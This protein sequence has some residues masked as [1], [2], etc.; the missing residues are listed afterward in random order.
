MVSTK[1]LVSTLLLA[2][3]GTFAPNNVAQAAVYS[4]GMNPGMALR[5]EENTILAWKKAMVEFLPRYINHDVKMP[6]EYSYTFGLL[7]DWL[8]WKVDWKDITYEYGEFDIR[9]CQFGFTNRF[10]TPMLQISFP[11]LK[12]W[13][14]HAMQK[15]N[16]WILPEESKVELEFKKFK[17]D[18][19]CQL[20]VT[21]EGYLKPITYG[22]DIKFGE[23]YLYHDNQFVA[24]IMHQVV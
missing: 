5:L 12:E 22:A 6:T 16:T 20:K 21:D 18:I 8:T 10:N 19:S 13:K 11:A 14:L 7:F 9:D 4:N 2:L 3:T 17:F 23:S 15:T 1:S 24:I